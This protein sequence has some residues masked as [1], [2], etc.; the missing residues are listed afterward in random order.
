[1]DCSN[2]AVDSVSAALGLTPNP[3]LYTDEEYEHSL[4]NL[5][6]EEHSDTREGYWFTVTT[7]APSV[8]HGGQRTVGIF[9]S[10]ERALQFVKGNPGWLW[11]FSYMFLC[12]E[13]VVPNACYGGMSGEEDRKAYW[14]VF[15]Q[16][17]E[18]GSDGEYLAIP[19]PSSENFEYL[20]SFAIG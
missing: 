2:N 6:L 11:E 1:M 14:Y 15:R 9:E 7:I 8:G 5:A 18:G 17:K 10:F 13:S 3:K 20:S 19:K 4:A 12:I 16:E